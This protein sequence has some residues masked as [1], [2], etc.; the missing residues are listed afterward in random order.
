M[1]LVITT[2]VGIVHRD[3][4]TCPVLRRATQRRPISDL[5]ARVYRL[6]HCPACFPTVVEYEHAIGRT[7][8]GL[9]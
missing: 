3:G 8:G 6:P 5:Q 9:K 2:D 7:R 4:T 1:T